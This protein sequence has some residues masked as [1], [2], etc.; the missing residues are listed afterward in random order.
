MDDVSA[1]VDVPG[2]NGITVAINDIAT[3]IHE[4]SAATH[5]ISAAINEIAAAANDELFN[6]NSVD[7]DGLDEKIS[8]EIIFVEEPIM[9]SNDPIITSD[10]INMD[11]ICIDSEKEHFSVVI[12]TPHGSCERLSH[13]KFIEFSLWNFPGARPPMSFEVIGL[14]KKQKYTRVGL[15]RIQTY[16]QESDGYMYLRTI[17]FR[18]CIP[19]AWNKCI[20]EIF[21]NLQLGDTQGLTKARGRVSALFKHERSILPSSLG[22]HEFRP[23][24]SRSK[25]RRRR[26]FPNYI[27]S[28]TCLFLDRELYL[29]VP[30]HAVLAIEL[31]GPLYHLSWLQFFSPSSELDPFHPRKNFL[32]YN[33]KKSSM[34][35]S[36]WMSSGWGGESVIGSWIKDE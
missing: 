12:Y 7:I 18:P 29:P 20:S 9:F 3:G 24:V 1:E 21:H 14:R 30:V 36:V 4:I 22:S 8:S 10:P 26:R 2:V 19:G 33:N 17:S 5:E 28:K 25:W 35:G 15:S 31:P 13:L 34:R 11:I 27:V 23:T 16:I 32:K 6:S